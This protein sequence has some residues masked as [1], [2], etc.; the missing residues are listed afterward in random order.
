MAVVSA[1]AS[2]PVE[3]FA[4]APGLAPFD[5][6]LGMPAL[7]FEAGPVLPRSLP[8][9]E[10]VKVSDLKENPYYPLV[11]RPRPRPARTSRAPFLYE[12]VSDLKS[13]PYL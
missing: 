9:A 1:H 12:R 3:R 7:L 11:T 5:L 10:P 8:I 13:N 4:S 2:L 6:P